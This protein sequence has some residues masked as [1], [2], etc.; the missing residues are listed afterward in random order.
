MIQNILIFAS[1]IAFVKLL[2]KLNNIR[3]DKFKSGDEEPCNKCVYKT[4]LETLNDVQA[5]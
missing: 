5:D 4:V 3:N 2:D 1:G